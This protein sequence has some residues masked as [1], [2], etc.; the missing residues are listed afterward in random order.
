M[1]KRTAIKNTLLIVLLFVIASVNAQSYYLLVG[2]YDSPKSEG[3][4]VYNFN[5]ND[6]SAKEISHIK[7]SNPSF[8]TVS[9]N[10]KYVYAVNENAD[11]SGKGGKVSSFSFNKK[12]GQLTFVNSQSSEGNHPCYITTNKSNSKVYVGNYSSGNISVLPISKKGKLDKAI[13]V[14]QH[15]GSGPD[16]TRQ[17]SP[18]VHGIFP[19]KKSSYVYVTDLGTDKIMCYFQ[20]SKSG[21]LFPS[22]TKYVSA[23]AGSGPRHLDFHPNGKY[24]YLL[25]ELSGSISVFK[26]FGNADLQ[27][28]QSHSSLPVTYKGKAG[29]AD[30]HISPDGR[31]LYASNRAGS[32]SIAI[33]SI[34]DATGLITLV[35]H[36]YSSGETPR[37]F[38]FDPTGNFLLV[39]NQ[40]SD[41]IVV[42]SINKETGLLSDTKKR[43][44]VGK[45]VCIKWINPR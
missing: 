6:G 15:E 25:N 29:S 18:H 3:I 14:I 36:E 39:A 20:G 38:N 16:T 27:E 1:L 42:F 37:N 24:V 43:I 10:Q 35:G 31:F 21:K 8:L 30:I 41:E 17:K 13:Q 45:P 22:K 12:D 19:K 34:N 4:Y 26:D 32:N 9:G 40:N 2:T 11:S 7:T 23:G 5:S 28:I 44:K 33:F